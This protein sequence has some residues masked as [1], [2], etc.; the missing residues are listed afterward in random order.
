L[1]VVRDEDFRTRIGLPAVRLDS[2]SETPAV[3]AQLRIYSLD[4][5]P[6]QQ[7]RVEMRDWVHP[8]RTFPIAVQVISLHPGD[9]LHPAFAE[10]DLQRA[11]PQLE[12]YEGTA[13]VDVVAMPNSDSTP[14]IWAFA[15]VTHNAT[16][17]VTVI[18]PQ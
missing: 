17:E 5:S 7:V 16:N 2:G 18:S 14:R 15:T 11:F 3:R 1:P 8:T 10:L 13:R 9:E 6:G 4:P 12:V